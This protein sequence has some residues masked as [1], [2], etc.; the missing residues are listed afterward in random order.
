MSDQPVAEAA[1]SNKL[2]SALNVE[3]AFALRP[4]V[5]GLGFLYLLFSIAHALVLPAPIKLPMV[6]VALLSV[7][8]F[9]FWWWRLQHW[10]PSAEFAHPL[11]TLFILVAGFNSI[12]HIWLSGEIHQSTNIAFI[13]IGTGCLLLSWNWFIVG[14]GATLMAWLAAISSLPSSPLTMH[15][16]F[17]LVSATV[18]AATI[19]GIRMRTVRGLIA[20]R[21][22]ESTYKYELQEALIQ[23]KMSEERFR[24]LAEATSE[25]VVLQDEGVVMDANE[26]F[27]EM[28]GYHRDEI[29]GHSLR[30]FVEPQSLQ[31]A[32]HKF[33][34]GDPY[35]VTALRKDGSTFIALVL[36]TNLPYSNRVVRVAAVRDITEQRHFENLLLSAKDQAE[37]ANRAKSTFLSTVSHELRTPL[38]AIVGYSEMIYED[39][40]DRSMPELAMDMTR[41]RSASDRLLS[42]ID[43]VLTITDL[44]A[45]VVRLEHETIDLALAIGSVS[46]QLQTKA[47]ENKNTIQLL[48]SQTWGSVV[49]DDHKLRMIIYH[50]LDNAI[51]FTHAGLISISV[52]RLQHAA[53]GWLEIA[54]RDTGIGVA[55]EQFERIFEPFV[56]A[57]SS[58]TRQYE[59]TGLGL[60][61][62]LRLAKAL[63]GTIELDSRLGLGSTFTL[64]L[65]EHPPHPNQQLSQMSHAQA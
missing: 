46:D 51:K 54:I 13:L 5:T 63:G 24:A 35:E 1:A 49:T 52:Q 7:L 30:E 42:L 15:F 65:P 53:G 9:A 44:D 11:A 64:H 47:Q 56:Q 18:A 48:G 28:F 32:M 6:I 3:V 25:G 55:H 12:L 59:G 61:V 31:K 39:L 16:I 2:Q 43:G 38:N 4:T 36:G 37:A 20:L 26:R 57:D 8:F 21:M 40:I 62:G 22:Q 10:R 58:A 34:D 27:G 33:K 50:L 23:I 14:I 41:I 17:M 45:E 29:I 19:Q 60:A